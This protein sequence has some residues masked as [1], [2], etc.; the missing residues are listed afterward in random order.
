M[1]QLAAQLA[2]EARLRF[3]KWDAE[4]WD[5]L[6]NGPAA[7]LAQGLRQARAPEAEAQQLG[8]SYLRLACEGIG[9]GYLFREST[10]ARSFL[11]LAF[12]H[13]LPEALPGLPA[14]RRA[15]T[16]AECWNLGENLERAPLWLGRIFVRLVGAGQSLG[17]LQ[18][19][20]QDVERR[21]LEA[22]AAR[23]GANFELRWVHLAD[24]DRRFLPGA[25]HFAAPTVVCV[26][27]R[28]R[29]TPQAGREAATLGVWLDQQPL[30]LG[31]LHC[32]EVPPADPGLDLELLE[33]VARRDP[34][35]GDWQAM[36]KNEWRA[37]LSLETSQF[38]VALLPP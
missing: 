14:E 8:E 15:S 16:L 29:G 3:A 21:A 5:E 23:L 27:D 12:Y 20:A 22:P 19:L 1:P 9:L 26:H 17:N 2:A 37:A 24:E 6:V 34:R 36:A 4:L 31:P 32:Q 10:D 13:L 25:L 28:H 38:L 33:S 30:T 18:A 11:T 7:T 35:A